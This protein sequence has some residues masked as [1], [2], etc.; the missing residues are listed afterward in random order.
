VLGTGQHDQVGAGQ[1]SRRARP[2]HVGDLLQPN[3]LVQV[4]GVRP[5]DDA[6]PPAVTARRPEGRALLVGQR[7]LDPGDD[8]DGRHPCDL[9]QLRRRRGQQ[10]DIAAELV[11]QK[12]AD[13]RPPERWQQ[14]PRA[15]QVGEGAAPIN[16]GDQQHGRVGQLGHAHVDDVVGPQVQL[17][18]AAGAL[19][20][21]H[22]V[23]GGERAIG[24]L[25]VRPQPR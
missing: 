15:I 25:D 21:D 16:V 8:A 2:T 14:R 13:V 7:V 12:P 20:H 24:G 17:S 23:L 22:V 19:D 3:E 18:R 5:A 9:L 1:R 11:E 4:G 10:P 6:H